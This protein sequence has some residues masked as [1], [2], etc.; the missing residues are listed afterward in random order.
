MKQRY[1]VIC[2]NDGIACP[3]LSRII[4]GCHRSSNQQSH[5]VNPYM[6]HWIIGMIGLDQAVSCN[7]INTHQHARTQNPFRFHRRIGRSARHN[8]C[9]QAGLMSSLINWCC[10]SKCNYAWFGRPS[11]QYWCFCLPVILLPTRGRLF[12]NHCN[13]AMQLKNN[14]AVDESHI[15]F[16]AAL[17]IFEE[18]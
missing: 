3:R 14:H 11:K 9:R 15:L 13:V 6:Q 7:F 12:V 17:T 16:F 1:E 2:E 5:R 4:Q 8:I 10:H 18:E